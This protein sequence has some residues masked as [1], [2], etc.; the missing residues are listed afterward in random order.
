M[1]L[2]CSRR[3]MNI[4]VVDI[5]GGIGSVKV[6]VHLFTWGDTN[7]FQSLIKNYATSRLTTQNPTQSIAEGVFEEYVAPNEHI[8]GTLGCHRSVLGETENN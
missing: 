5:D 6:K 4:F 2:C 3:E 7:I 8:G 1:L